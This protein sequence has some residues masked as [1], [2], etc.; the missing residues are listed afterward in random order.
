[1]VIKMNV[2]LSD[3]FS[4]ICRLA[5]GLVVTFNLNFT[6]AIAQSPTDAL[7]M[8][9]QELCIAGMV[10]QDKWKQYWE[11]TLLRTNDNI[12][13]LTRRTYMPMAAYGITSKLTVIAALPYITTQ[14]SGG[15]MA[16]ASGFQDAGLFLKYKWLD[17][18][19]ES[20]NFRAF[21]TA[22]WGKPATSYLADYMPLQLGLGCQELSARAIFKLEWRDHLYM[23]TGI[24]YIQRGTAKAERDYY[25]TDKGIYTN[26]MD[27]PSAL[28]GEAAVGAWLIGHTLQVEISTFAQK[29]LAGD[30][31]RRQNAP[32]PTN[33][34]NAWQAG[35]RLRYFASFLNNFSLIAE[36]FQVVDGRNVGKSSIYTLGVTWQGYVKK[37]DK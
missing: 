32:Q 5:C 6:N 16:G 24:G 34:M 36:H 8:D 23:R 33:K 30:D 11:G 12:G 4:A 15:Q 19:R 17:E 18:V 35:G 22:G 28:Q 27:V 13:T 26:I 9:K 31:I 1:M 2:N 20:L 3:Y 37:T 25:Y 14:A 21:T 10:S 29:S 7:M